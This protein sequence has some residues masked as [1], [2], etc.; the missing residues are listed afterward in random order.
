MA[1]GK[2]LGVPELMKGLSDGLIKASRR[3]NLWGYSPHQKQ[4]QF[5]TSAAKTRLYIGGNRS[6]KTVGGC[7]EDIWWL[8]GRHP[9]METPPPP[10]RGRIIGV[11]FDNGIEKILKPEITRW[12]PP[13]ALIDG[14]WEKSFNKGLRTLTLANGSFLEFMS[15][16]QEVDKF[17]GTSRHFVHFDEEP[18]QPVYIE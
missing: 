6:G 11:D 10:V 5:H 14:S 3:P 2:S 17:A 13:S 4:I 7:V 15:Y 8:M 12:I 16:V 9:Y 1:K 18:P